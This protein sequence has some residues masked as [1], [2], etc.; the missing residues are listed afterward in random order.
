MFLYQ[1]LLFVAEP[2]LFLHSVFLEKLQSAYLFALRS[3]RVTLG[4]MA[5]LLW[6]DK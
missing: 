4:P 5:N 3:Y 6:Y 2:Q 1:K